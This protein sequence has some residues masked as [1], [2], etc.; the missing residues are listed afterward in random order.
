MCP[1]YFLGCKDKPAFELSKML[2]NSDQVPDDDRFINE[3]VSAFEHNVLK[4]NGQHEVGTIHK[5]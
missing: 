5:I 3:L 2:R 4:T 1:I